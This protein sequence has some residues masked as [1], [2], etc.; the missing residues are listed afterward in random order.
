MPNALL[1]YPEHP[2]TYWGMET[3]LEVIGKKAMFPPLGLLTIAAMFP[4]EYDLRLV[5]LNVTPLQDADLDWADI[6]FT[7]TMIV[8]RVSL[9]LVIDRCNQA[10]V[11]VVAGGASPDHVSRRDQGRGPLR[12]GRGRGNLSP[13]FT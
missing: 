4:P 3:A 5:D 2:P 7:S 8:Q 9:Q 13:I 1:I 12:S 6:A 11:P 10:G